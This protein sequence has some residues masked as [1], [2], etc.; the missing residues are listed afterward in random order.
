ME[1]IFAT[2]SRCV[3]VCVI[4]EAFGGAQLE[5][6]AAR[7]GCPGA[8]LAAVR[9]DLAGCVRDAEPPLCLQRRQAGP[10]GAPGQSDANVT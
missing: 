1:T 2:F 7:L 6:C 9:R 5:H 10:R 8:Q 4:R 3:C